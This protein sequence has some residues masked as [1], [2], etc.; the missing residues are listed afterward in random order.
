[1]LTA[2]SCSCSRKWPKNQGACR[3][4]GNLLA[5]QTKEEIKICTPKTARF[6]FSRAFFGHPLLHKFRAYILPP[7][8]WLRSISGARE[9]CIIKICKFQ[10]FRHS[11][12]GTFG[13]WIR[14][15]SIR[16]RVMDSELWVT[17]QGWASVLRNRCLPFLGPAPWELLAVNNADGSVRRRVGQK[18]LPRAAA[19][20]PFS[21][22]PPNGH[23]AG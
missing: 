16:L 18:S 8:F 17:G 13:F 15:R 1:M 4:T 9:S 19:P 11:D 2:S 23:V 14:P 20:N 7:T 12:I 3:G 10:T 22:P 21:P 5:S 6:E